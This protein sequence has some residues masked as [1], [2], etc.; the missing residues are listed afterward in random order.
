MIKKTG[1]IL[2][3]GESV[4]TSPDQR[5]IQ[6]VVLGPGRHF[7]DPINWDWEL[8]PLTVIPSGNPKTWNLTQ[9]QAEVRRGAPRGAA[10]RSAGSFPRLGV[11][12]RKVGKRAPAGQLIVKRDS[13]YQ[14]ILEEVLTPGTYK[15][16][17]YVYEVKLYPATMIPAG[18]VGVVTNL[19]GE[20]D[21]GGSVPVQTAA[22]LPAAGTSESLEAE[23]Q[24]F[25]RHVRPLAQPG[26]RG[27]LRDVLQP[28]IYFINP[29][30][31]KVTLIEIGFNEFSQLQTRTSSD[32]QISFPSDT[33]YLIQTVVR[34][35]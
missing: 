7:R 9:V 22:P 2:P 21:L 16:N 19:F 12:T 35:Q 20:T 8:T 17:P 3:P 4:A 11:V 25:V 18:F 24:T 10:P 5:G 27:T 6:E 31:K 32:E 26:E 14:G 29:K 30:L 15:L 33:G 13:Q 1:E 34:L 28:G 23:D